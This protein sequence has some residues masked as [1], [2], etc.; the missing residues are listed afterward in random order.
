[1]SNNKDYKYHLFNYFL[2]NFSNKNH[3]DELLKSDNRYKNHLVEFLNLAD[4]KGFYITPEH[5]E[6][7]KTIEYQ[8]EF[9][10]LLLNE[11]SKSKI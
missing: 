10:L 7:F 6:K 1:M 3:L 2:S 4:E 8:R 5:K 9:L 11:H